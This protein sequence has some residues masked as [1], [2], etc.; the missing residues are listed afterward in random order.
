MLG[1]VQ[2]TPGTHFAGAGAC[3]LEHVAQQS[4]EYMAMEEDPKRVVPLST[5]PDP[6]VDVCIFFLS[7][8]FLKPQDVSL[9]TR[10]SA[11]VPVVPVI[12]KVRPLAACSPCLQPCLSHL[13][14]SL[15][16]RCRIPT[17][18]AAVMSPGS[19]I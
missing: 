9:M 16:L 10:L 7:P 15:P 6:R 2:D 3:V 17:G 5:L 12:A 14:R 11:S 18:S 4:R 19:A 13:R 8:H 1:W